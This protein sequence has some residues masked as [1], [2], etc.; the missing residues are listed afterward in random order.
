MEILIERKSHSSTSTTNVVSTSSSSTSTSSSLSSWPSSWIQ[1][2]S[3]WSSSKKGLFVT[4]KAR[5]LFHSIRTNLIEYKR[6][7]L[8][9][10]TTLLLTSQAMLLTRATRHHSSSFATPTGGA[11]V[12]TTFINNASNDHDDNH[13][14]NNIHLPHGASGHNSAESLSTAF[15]FEVM[16]LFIC[17]VLMCLTQTDKLTSL[18]KATYSSVASTEARLYGVP[19]LLHIINDNILFGI[20]T[21]VEST[22]FEVFQIPFVSLCV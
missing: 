17:C 5:N 10:V 15:L 3:R 7:H 14:H 8:I 2:W 22:T 12:L 21:M 6:D 16:K 9:G 19:A 13:M 18:I 4:Q 1:W 11:S 20:L